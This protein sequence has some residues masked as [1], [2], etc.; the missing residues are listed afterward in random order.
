MQ[1]YFGHIPCAR[2]FP[3]PLASPSDAGGGEPLIE[4]LELVVRVGVEV[5]ADADADA[6]VEV[7][8]EIEAVEVEAVDVEG[9]GW[10]RSS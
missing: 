3:F 1:Q 7:E 4:W 8:V 10:A 9:S 2:F 5:D 6:G